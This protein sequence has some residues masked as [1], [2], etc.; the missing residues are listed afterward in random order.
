MAH[1]SVRCPV[2]GCS[3]WIIGSRIKLI[4]LLHVTHSMRFA[5]LTAECV[6]LYIRINTLCLPIYI[7]QHCAMCICTSYTLLLYNK[8]PASCL[9]IYNLLYRNPSCFQLQLNSYF[10]LYQLLHALAFAH[11]VNM[12]LCTFSN[13]V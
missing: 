1:E 10:A 9:L 7:I 5:G 11:L 4:N 3:C 2:I 13:F 8:P 12:I 6:S